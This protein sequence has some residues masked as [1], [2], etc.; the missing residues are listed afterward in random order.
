MTHSKEEDKNKVGD[1]FTQLQARI[2]ASDWGDPRNEPLET[3]QDCYDMIDVGLPPPHDPPSFAEVQRAYRHQL[4]RNDITKPGL[5]Q[6]AIVY[7]A[8]RLECVQNAY[9]R[10]CKLLEKDPDAGLEETEDVLMAERDLLLK[11]WEGHWCGTPSLNIMQEYK[12]RIDA[13]KNKKNAN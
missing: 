5:L 7:R 12:E 6:E 11:G 9:L 2:A 13:L 8:I 10:V 3:L 1:W 4:W